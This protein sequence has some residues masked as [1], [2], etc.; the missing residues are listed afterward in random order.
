MRNHETDNFSRFINQRKGVKTFIVGT[1]AML[2]LNACTFSS[3]DDRSAHQ[4][5]TPTTESLAP[6]TV[7][8]AETTTT[9]ICIKHPA[10]SPDYDIAQDA[11]WTARQDDDFEEAAKLLGQIEDSGVRATAERA[12]DLAEAESSVWE[13]RQYNNFEEADAIADLIGEPVVLS[14]AEAGISAAQREDELWLQE[15]RDVS[16]WAEANH[17]SLTLWHDLYE[18]SLKAWHD[19][20]IQ[21]SDYCH[22]E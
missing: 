11:V 19:I 16:L 22:P 1:V 14:L 4:E 10:V 18:Q 17:A 21:S 3:G 2:A 12:V 15:P 7:S 6:T 8:P 20:Y 13:A 5:V 9:T